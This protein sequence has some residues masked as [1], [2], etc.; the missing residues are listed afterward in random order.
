MP[1]NVDI[2]KNL[3]EEIPIVHADP[4]Q[5]TQVFINLCMNAIQAMPDGGQ[6]TIESD[7]F[8]SDWV[9]VSF[10]DTGSG[11]PEENMDRLFEPLFTTKAKGIGL[12][13]AITKSFV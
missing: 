11:I 4:V 5:I 3:R 10:T 7:V 9:S 12:G 2:V 13:L 1:E 6:L 8:H